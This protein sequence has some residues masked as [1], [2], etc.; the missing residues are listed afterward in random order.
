M[1]TRRQKLTL[2]EKK[3]QSKSNRMTHAKGN[4]NYAIKSEYLNTHGGWG[5]E[6][7]DKPWK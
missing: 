6:Y 3:R 7:E 5:F 1:K 4:S 2:R